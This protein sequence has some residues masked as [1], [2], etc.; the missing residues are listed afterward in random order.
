[1]LLIKSPCLPQLIPTETTEKYTWQLEPNPQKLVHYQ[2]QEPQNVRA[3]L[4]R[5]LFEPKPENIRAMSLKPRKVL[6]HISH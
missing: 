5:I 3:E 6:F 1:M 2:P 4:S